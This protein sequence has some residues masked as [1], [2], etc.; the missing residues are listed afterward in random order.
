METLRYRRWCP[1]ASPLRIEFPAELVRTLWPEPD[2]L[3]T[4]GVLY[5]FHRAREVHIVATKPGDGLEAVG[6]FAARVRGEVFLTESNLELFERHKVA[7]AFVR[8]G[9]K[10]GFFARESNGSIQT[11]RSHEEFSVDE[12]P[13]AP[14]K[15]PKPAACPRKAAMKPTAWAAVGSLALTLPLLAFFRPA[16]ALG[17]EV[18]EQAGQLRISWEPGKPA[19]IEIDDGADHLSVPLFASQRSLTYARSTGE[20]DVRLTIEDGSAHPRR[21]SA[22]FIAG[23]RR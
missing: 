7:V 17:L 5:G 8:A 2:E 3:E 13:L 12:S 19:V 15:P 10:A 20:V 14:A 16:P 1:P 9:S 21:E 23:A 6:I 18:R 4:S 11:V 22:R